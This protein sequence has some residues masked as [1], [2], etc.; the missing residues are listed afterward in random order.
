MSKDPPS[1]FEDVDDDNFSQSSQSKQRNQW[2]NEG[3]MKEEGNDEEMESLATGVPAAVIAIDDDQ[4]Q[5][6]RPIAPTSA[7]KGTQ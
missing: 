4:E 1:P 7:Q 6:F 5:I 2:T 3:S